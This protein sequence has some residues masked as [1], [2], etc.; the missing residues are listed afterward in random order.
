MKNNKEE[1]YKSNLL[2]N[3]IIKLASKNLIHISDK[4]YLERLYKKRM[5][6]ELNL[7]NPKTFNEKLQWLKL[8][9]RKLEYIKMVDKYEAKKYVENLIGKEYIIPTIGIYDKFEDIDFEKLPNQFVIKCTHDSGGIVICKDKNTFNKKEAK[10]KIQRAL[11]RN[12]YYSKREWVY[13]EIKPRIIIEEYMVDE[14][15]L[16]LK[17]Y[18]IFC[19]NGEPKFIQVDFDRFST[20]KRNIYTL[21]WKLLNFSIEYPSD[22]N[23]TI[24][25]PINLKKMIQ[26]AKELSK[27]IPHVRVD[28]YS[29]NEKI[30]FGELTFYHGAGY[31]RFKPIEWDKKMG[32]MIKL[33]E[34]NNTY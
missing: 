22:L 32:D 21:D 30:Y 16:E 23:R 15:G 3:I 29:I 5:H 12:Y 31:E 4:N 17:D 25:K 13:K 8:Y 20:H 27:N 11:K 9:D 24:N 6:K 19:F 18:K 33:P 1:N 10:K 34:K 14:S 28:F 7:E 2:N 26:F